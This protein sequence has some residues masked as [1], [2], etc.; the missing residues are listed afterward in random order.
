LDRENYESEG[1]LVKTNCF[2]MTPVGNKNAETLDLTQYLV[3]IYPLKWSYDDTGARVGLVHV[4]HDNKRKTFFTEQ[5]ADDGA[6]KGDEDD[7]F[8]AARRNRSSILSRR[9][10]NKCQQDRALNNQFF[11]S[12]SV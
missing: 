2:Q 5:Q 9:I 4:V 8:K 3:Q 7:A 10:L 6:S 11:V 12:V 1:I